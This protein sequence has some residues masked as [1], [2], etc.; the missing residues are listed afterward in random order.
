MAREPRAE[1]EGGKEAVMPRNPK[2]RPPGYTPSL[3]GCGPELIRPVSVKGEALPATCYQGV[4]T[5]LRAFSEMLDELKLTPAQAGYM[6]DDLL[7]V[8]DRKSVV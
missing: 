6:G 5:K 1:S 7:D 3:P 8:P 2:R 4:Q